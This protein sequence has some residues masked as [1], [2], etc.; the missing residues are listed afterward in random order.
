MRAWSRTQPTPILIMPDGRATTAFR[1][2]WL[3]RAHL[4]MSLIVEPREKGMNVIVGRLQDLPF[5]S[6]ARLVAE[7]EQTGWMFLRRLLDEWAAGTNRFDKPGEAIFAAWATGKLIGVCG[8][9]VDPYIGD[10]RIGRVRH[11]YVL[12]DF[13]RLGVGRRLVEAVVAA[14]RGQ[15]V[16]LRLRTE[17]AEAAEFYEELGFQRW[18]EMSDCT[19]VREI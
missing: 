11:L 13:R 9:N 8:L 7:S 16:S 10:G 6:M 5:D 17:S 15:F 14:A 1:R 3:S 12:S 2:S 18:S 19:H 4:E